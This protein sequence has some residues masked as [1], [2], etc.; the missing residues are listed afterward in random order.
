MITS[1]LEIYAEVTEF[2]E[3]FGEIKAR[4][5]VESQLCRILRSE[6]AI[7]GFFLTRPWDFCSFPPGN[8]ANN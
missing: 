4:S 1:F 5:E 3:N 2:L 6:S 7:L 8:C